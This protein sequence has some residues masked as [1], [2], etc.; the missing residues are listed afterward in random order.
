[1]KN[2]VRAHH[3]EVQVFHRCDDVVTLVMLS[4][5]LDKDGRA[6]ARLWTLDNQTIGETAI[7][8]L[9]KYEPEIEE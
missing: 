4:V 1:M 7:V 6:K 2:V 8:Q 9:A 3:V 5:L